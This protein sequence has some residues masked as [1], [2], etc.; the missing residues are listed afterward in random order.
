MGGFAR[1]ARRQRTTPHER[2]ASCEAVTSVAVQRAR[3][4]PGA[5]ARNRPSALAIASPR[6]GGLALAAERS[7]SGAVRSARQR[8][9]KAEVGQ[10]GVIDET[11]DRRDPVALEREHEQALGAQNGG[12]RVAKVAAE[13][14]LAVRA[15]RH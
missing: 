6:R 8:P 4:E 12:A 2:L 5:V 1:R 3:S 7:L 9:G 11:R 14:R 10:R 13:R 15:R